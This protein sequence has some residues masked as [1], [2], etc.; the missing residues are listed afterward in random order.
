MSG[1]RHFAKTCLKPE[2][3]Q[4][5]IV[6]VEHWLVWIVAAAGVA[7]SA[8]LSAV[9]PPRT[10]ISCG[11]I[12]TPSSLVGLPGGSFPPATGDWL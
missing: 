4:P 6:N 7:P 1:L 8:V 11:R 5:E 10:V 2:T 3:L 9:H 12:L